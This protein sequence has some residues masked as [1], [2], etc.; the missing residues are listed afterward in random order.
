MAS[1]LN[2]LPQSVS[3]CR[4]AASRDSPWSVRMRARQAGCGSHGVRRHSPC[5]G[6][7]GVLTGSLTAKG[8][9]MSVGSEPGFSPGACVCMPGRPGAGARCETAFPMLR[10]WRRSACQR[11]VSDSTGLLGR[12][13]PGPRAENQR[14]PGGDRRCSVSG[15]ASGFT[16]G[17]GSLLMGSPVMGSK[18]APEG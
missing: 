10:G 5:C 1:L 14:L 9:P 18:F 12:S 7:G 17:W 4:W 3:R 15:Y 13:S 16:G 8:E 6:A 2:C 11:A